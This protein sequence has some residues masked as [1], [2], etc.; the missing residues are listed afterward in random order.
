MSVVSISLLGDS[1]V[2]KTSIFHSYLDNTF[3]EDTMSTSGIDSRQFN[4]EKN[5]EHYTIRL[6]DTA[7]Q[8]RYKA[9]V[10]SYYK[11]CQGI[12]LVYDVTNQRSFENISN[13]LSDIYE[14][15][16]KDMPLILVG[17]KIDL[18]PVVQEEDGRKK[19]EECKCDFYL[20]S[21]KS[22]ENVKKAVDA[23]IDQAIDQ[24]IKFDLHSNQI[25]LNTKSNYNKYCC[26]KHSVY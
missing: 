21:A 20:V 18:K 8:E 23:L 15:A 17:N 14:N 9:M 4:L 16:S 7:G 22:H 10:K 13:W 12:L 25:Y 6:S 11:N 19:A 5:E 1:T 3:I 24:K 26:G 2:G